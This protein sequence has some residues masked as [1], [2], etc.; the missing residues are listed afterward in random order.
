MR[1]YFISW[2]SISW[3]SNWAFHSLFSHIRHNFL[4]IYFL[5]PIYVLFTVWMPSLLKISTISFGVE[6]VDDAF[7]LF[8]FLRGGVSSTPNVFCCWLNLG[9]NY[10]SEDVV[11]A[12]DEDVLVH[13]DEGGSESPP[14]FFTRN[15]F[16]WCFKTSQALACGKYFLINKHKIL[17]LCI[18]LKHLSQNSRAPNCSA[19]GCRCGWNHYTSFEG[20]SIFEFT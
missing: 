16:A 20:F 1:K 9:G 8:C 3:A 7:F 14:T 18:F 6:L 10:A 13:F 12:L 17:A 4:S 19:Y 11:K 5:S 15:H 2:S